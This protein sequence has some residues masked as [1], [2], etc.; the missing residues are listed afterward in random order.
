MEASYTIPTIISADR[1]N[2]ISILEKL[3]ETYVDP[4][5]KKMRLEQIPSE[6]EE[7]LKMFPLRKY[8]LAVIGNTNVGKSTFLN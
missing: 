3:N 7:A 8:E 6:I 5:F 2:A 4:F 1:R